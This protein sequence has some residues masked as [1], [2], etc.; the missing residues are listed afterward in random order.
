MKVLVVGSGGREHALC[1]AIRHSSRV[2]EVICGPGNG[3]IA[4]V[5]RCVKANPKDI[6][7]LL[8]LMAEEKPDLTVVGPE[9]PLSLGF[10]DAAQQRGFRI[11]GPT[12]EAAQLET[13]KAYAKRFMQRHGIRSPD[14]AV[15]ESRLERRNRWRCFICRW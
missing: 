2:S 4:Q 8:R 3:G 12:Q 11:F 7:D 6:D 5:A 14:Y 1:A 10:V 13:S 9:M 15:C